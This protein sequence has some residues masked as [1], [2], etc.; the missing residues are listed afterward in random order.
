MLD[1][2]QR[3]VI[4]I[5]TGLLAVPICVCLYGF[6]IG[7]EWL[8]FKYIADCLVTSFALTS[9]TFLFIFGKENFRKMLTAKSFAIALL[10]VFAVGLLLYQPLNIL[11]ATG[12]SLE[13]ETD[14]IW[15]HRANTVY[16][17]D[18]EGIERHK[19]VSLRYI[20]TDDD[21]LWPE[22]GGSMIVR[23]TMGGF[24]LKFFE[25]VEVTY[26]PGR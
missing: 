14:I 25:I 19:D 22:T 13:Y 11:S 24:H 17:Y 20:V 7:G 26:E 3:A 16:F 21:V 4:V 1:K 9:F 23:E 5:I 2:K 12:E 15:S 8:S 10:A 6:T 18:S